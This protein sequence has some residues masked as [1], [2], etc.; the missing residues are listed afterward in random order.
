MA[1]LIR[2]CGKEQSVVTYLTLVSTSVSKIIGFHDP[3]DKT[4]RERANVARTTL[5]HSTSEHNDYFF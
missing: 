5:Q 1:L 2:Q 4:E 3:T